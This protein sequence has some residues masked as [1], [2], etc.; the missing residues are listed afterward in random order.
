MILD[1]IVGIILLISIIQGYRKGFIF[2]LVHTVSWIGSIILGFVFY[3]K[4]KTLLVDKTIVYDSIYKKI[5][6]V[7]LAKGQESITSLT[8][9][10]PETL[11]TTL[12]ATTSTAS[13]ALATNI[14]NAT[15]SIITFLVILLSIKLILFLISRIFIKRSLKKGKGFSNFIDGFFGLLLGA[16]K[17]FIL[18]FI[19]LMILAPISQLIDSQTLSDQIA[20]SKFTSNLYNGNFI[21]FSVKN[22][23]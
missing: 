18:V 6:E 21:L 13:E 23:F 7:L 2:T 19:L 22:L 8:N 15:I 14:A 9:H 11:N 1:I 4:I 16:V 3:D 10:L 12:T 20:S 17:G 5:L